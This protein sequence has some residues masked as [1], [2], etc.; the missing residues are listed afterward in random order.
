MCGFG[1][2]AWDRLFGAP[3]PAQLHP[4]SAIGISDRLA[5]STPGDI[6]LHIRADEMDL[7]FELATQLLKKLGAAV[8]A[9]NEVHGFRYFDQRAM[10]SLVNGTENPKDMRR[11]TIGLSARKTR[12]SAVAAMC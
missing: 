5:V 1:S 11:S 2:A 12:R 10:V 4:F 7:C 6:L 8:T 9:V 3:R